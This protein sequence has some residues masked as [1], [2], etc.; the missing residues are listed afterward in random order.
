MEFII[1]IIRIYEIILL[2]RIILSWIQPNPNNKYLGWIY[3]VT[4]P[5]LAPIRKILPLSFGSIDFSPIVVFIILDVFK[6]IL[7]GFI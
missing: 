2:L 6:R 7:N 5:I 4:E 3:I 1:I